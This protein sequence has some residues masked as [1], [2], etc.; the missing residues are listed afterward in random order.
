LRQAQ[1]KT[2]EKQSCC[3]SLTDRPVVPH[4]HPYKG[5]QLK[6]GLVKMK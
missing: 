2:V 6:F 3:Q 5:F 1:T 4:S